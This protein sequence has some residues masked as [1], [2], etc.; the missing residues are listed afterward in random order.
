MKILITGAASGIGY[1]LA[2]KLIKNG[3]YV[4][5]CVH[6]EKEIKNVIEKIKN[7]NYQDR[8][9]VIKL[10]ITNKKDRTLIEKLD[11]DCLVN[12]AGIGIGGSL[13]NMEVKEIKKNFAVNFFSTLELTKLYIKTRKNKQGKVIITSSL[14][15][16]YPIAFL[17]SY[18]ASKASLSIMTRVLQ[19]EIKNTNLNIFI[20]VYKK[21][22][23]RGYLCL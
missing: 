10:D 22:F 5:L 19:K 8:V 16:V 7:I 18:C 4:Y 12:Q 14:A 13:L 17:G 1:S 21:I 9:S 15:G 3:H 6:H 11:I 2:D 23:K 20:I